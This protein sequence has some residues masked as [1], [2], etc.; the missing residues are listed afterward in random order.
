MSDR[1]LVPYDG[2]PPSVKA[3]EYAFDTFP[4]ADITALYVVPAPEGYWSAF[5]G[6]KEGRSAPDRATDRGREILDEATEIA[7]EHDHALD[8][9]L[10][11]GKPE[12]AIVEQTVDGAYDTVVIGSHGREGIS[13]V[14]LGSVAETV[15]RRAPVP[16]LVV[17]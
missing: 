17:R 12:R 13:R 16:V 11:V 14:L 3:L 8:T 5:Q 4:G 6:S 2:S 15:V 7:D 9:E 1:T 10:V